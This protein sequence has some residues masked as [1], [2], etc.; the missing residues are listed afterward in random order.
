MIFDSNKKNEVD[1]AKSLQKSEMTSQKGPNDEFKLDSDKN[2]DGRGAR[3]GL[4]RGG[5]PDSGESISGPN[6][7]GGRGG[8]NEVQ[9]ILAAGDG[10]NEDQ[11]DPG[12]EPELNSN[13]IQLP[14]D[15][16]YIE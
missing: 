13:Q 8:R 2:D 12:H 1:L 7:G 4:G 15:D 5:G 14:V 11:M 16:D 10:P 6:S 3:S 9:P